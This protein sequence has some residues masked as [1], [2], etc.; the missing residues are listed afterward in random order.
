MVDHINNG[1]EGSAVRAKLNTV[2]DRTNALGGIES[3]VE[4]NKRLSEQ[5]RDRL[6]NLDGTNAVVVGW[7]D[8]TG[9]PSAFPPQAH[10]HQ[11]SEV[12]GLEDRLT[13]IEGSIVDGGGFVDAPDDGKLYGRQ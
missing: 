12:N 4:T 5:N 1:E 8:V 9:K 2:I 13:S 10:T 7:D 6:D 11:Q 3:K